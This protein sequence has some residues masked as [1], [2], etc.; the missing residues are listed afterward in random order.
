MTGKSSNEPYTS[1]WWARADAHSLATRRRSNAR[2]RTSSSSRTGDLLLEL[3]QTPESR[4]DA[5]RAHEL[6]V[7]PL[8]DD[9]AL[10]ED[11]DARCR[12]RGA[13]TVRHQ[14]P[15]AA[16][17]RGR[18][19]P[20]DLLFLQGVNAREDVVQD[21]HRRGAGERARERQALALPARHRESALADDRLEALREAD[22]LVDDA[23]GGRHAPRLGQR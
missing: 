13:E 14:E 6:L 4:V 1:R 19:V 3:L 17:G 10:D 16:G 18:E 12:A 21:E 11:D 23:G 15:G 20:H 9:T 2:P 8:L 5:A 7:R 22:D